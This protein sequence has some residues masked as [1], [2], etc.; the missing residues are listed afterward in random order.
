MT[1]TKPA[2]TKEAPKW[3]TPP[4]VPA[5]VQAEVI[6]PEQD[7]PVPAIAEEAPELPAPVF[8]GAGELV[9]APSDAEALSAPF[10]MA[11]INVKPTKQGEVYIGHQ[12]LAARMNT[13]LGIGQWALVPAWPEHKMEADNMHMAYDLTIRG[14]WITRAI[15]GMKYQ[16]NNDRM[17]YSDALEGVRSSALKRAAKHLGVGLECWSRSF[18]EKFRAE[19]CIRVNVQGN[20]GTYVAWRRSDAEPLDRE[21]G[22]YDPVKTPRPA[23]QQRPPQ[24]AKPAQ[25]MQENGG[26]VARNVT[27][28]VEYMQVGDQELWR[29]TGEADGKTYFTDAKPIGTKLTAMRE[30][31][32]VDLMYER[33][34]T[35]DYGFRILDVQMG[36]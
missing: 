14:H 30:R 25:P 35:P 26:A 24:Q 16:P 4:G 13:V 7:A 29:I 20:R 18:C 23:Q 10:E 3:G 19:H 17:D 12:V 9:L 21:Q 5:T 32:A 11:D 28:K 15:G 22:E 31:F 27:G 34:E 36:A 1:A 6:P 33:E 2:E 8:Q